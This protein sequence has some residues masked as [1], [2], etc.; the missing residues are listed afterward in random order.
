MNSGHDNR[1][2]SGQRLGFIGLGNMGLPMA[3]HIHNAGGDLRV[4][5]RGQAR[6]SSA[7][8]LG[9]IPVGSLAELADHVGSGIV[10]INLTD[11]DVI[12]SL[13]FGNQGLCS[14][15]SSEAMVIDF[16]TTGVTAT[17]FFATK[18]RWLD[19][20]VSGGQVGAEA[21]NLSIMAGGALDDFQRALPILETVG[22]RII[23]VGPSGAGQV[24]KLANQLVVAQTIDAV[25]QALRI[26]ELSG[27]K[28]SLAREAM[29]GGFAAS[30]VLE[31]HGSR[32]EKKDFAPGGR[33]Q[34]QLKDIRLV[35]ELA[36]ELG[37]HSSTLSNCLQLWEEMIS[38][39]WGEYDHSGL[40]KLYE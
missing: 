9:L 29:L 10:C 36:T 18:L 38:R 14:Y 7:V 15:L 40:Y 11:S 37:F 25:A 22:N 3:R 30:R 26:V 23:H 21:A 31:L 2:L 34:L 19:A 4:W 24:T 12:H 20:P 1:R 13:I 33:A 28:I 16:G 6:L 27:I 35:C 32:M 5:N 39:G 8:N 17:K